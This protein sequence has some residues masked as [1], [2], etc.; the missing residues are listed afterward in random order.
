M[1]RVNEHYLKLKSSYLFSEIA[2]RLTAFQAAHPGAKIIRLGIGDVTL[3]LAPAIIRALHEAVDEMARPETFRGY[4]PEPGYEFLTEQI[5][6]HDYGTRGVRVSP[7]EL[8][9]SDGGKSDSANIQEI[10]APDCVVAVTDPVYPVYVDS[11]VM[12]GRGGVPDASGR[13]AGLV[14]LPCTA[15]NDF[16]P[17]LPDRPVD[18]IYLCYPNNPTGA[19]MTKA[20]LKRW[21]DY[22]RRQG[23]VL[24]YDAAY[25]AYIREP[26]I[27]HSIF[28]VEGAREVA[29][30]FRSFSKTAGFTG[31][32]CAFTVVPQ[33]LFGVAASGERVSLHALWLRRQSTKFNGVPYIVQ[34]AAAAVY[35][36]EGARQVRGQVDYYLDNA[37]IIRE[38]LE[39]IGL[40]VY[41]GKNAPYL[42]VK[43]P[44][45]LD[46]WA[47]FDKLLQE[48]H[49]VGTPGAGFGPSGE[50]YLRLTAFG[51]RDETEE[52]VERI[53]TRLAL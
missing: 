46:S 8:F 17:A 40:R 4:G 22:A 45:R 7:D 13:Y 52:A 39:A 51:R 18:L 3:P 31:T 32:R 38:G 47:F 24:L 6:A 27:P 15:E 41:G 5:A 37:R 1:A 35:T 10:F 30:E 53:K 14:Y 23:A 43:T 19:V 21:V 29:V 11:N 9:V 44:G 12:A 25:E 49:V 34:K 50:G 48:A 36:E 16:Q 33:E 28:E 2:R 42:W 20:A 26:G